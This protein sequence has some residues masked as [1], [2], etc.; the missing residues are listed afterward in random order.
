MFFHRNLLN[1][2]VVFLIFLVLNCIIW[3]NYMLVRL[4]WF[5]FCS[6]HFP[7]TTFFSIWNCSFNIPNGPSTLDFLAY[8]FLYSCFFHFY[9]SLLFAFWNCILWLFLCVCFGDNHLFF[10]GF[11]VF[12]RGVIVVMSFYFCLVFHG[13][14]YEVLCIY[15]LKVHI[16]IFRIFWMHLI[17]NHIRNCL[18]DMD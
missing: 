14:L 4:S 9:G 3:L 18:Y 12:T 11:A 15:G 8:S 1:L 7:M 6:C 13:G 17:Y 10:F 5:F 16:F 2:P